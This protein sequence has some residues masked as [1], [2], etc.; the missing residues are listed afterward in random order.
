MSEPR[1]LV[2]GSTMVD[3]IA[4]AKRL[5]EAGETIVGDRFQIGLGGKGANQAVMAAR[6][7]VP[8]AMVNAVGD[9]AYGATH[10]KNFADEGID[11]TWMRTVKGSSGV[12][13]IWVD[14]SGMNRII[15]ILGANDATDP[16]VA[17]QAVHEVHPTIVVAQLETPQAT[18]VA[19]FRAAREKG[20]ATLLNPAPARPIVPELLSLTDWLTPNESEFAALFGG[21]ATGPGA[22]AR[23]RAAADA[24]KVNL[25]V[26]L[27]VEGAALALPGEPVRH[28]AAP[29]V[30][31]VDTTGA[32]DSFVGAFSVGLVRGLEPMRAAELACACASASVQKHGTQSSYLSREEARALAAPYLEGA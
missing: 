17:V 11:T 13:P 26:T 29:K 15:T 5:P 23:I 20:I 27:G 1:I 10:M 18:T 12:A 31:V 9:D 4:Y 16:A 25:I 21:E 3:L 7:G 24:N 14:A 28:V 19:A 6:F 30:P 22:D 8:V 32:G 2:V